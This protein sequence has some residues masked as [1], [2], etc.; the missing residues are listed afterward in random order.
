MEEDNAIVG[1]FCLMLVK[2]WKR[3]WNHLGL[4]RKRMMLTIQ[5]PKKIHNRA[6]LMARL[7]K[8]I[9]V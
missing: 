1:N 3:N 6:T 7:L 5:P 4:R 9:K 8:R 2:M